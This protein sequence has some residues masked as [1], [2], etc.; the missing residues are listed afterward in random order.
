MKKFF[1]TAMFI[2][3]IAPTQGLIASVPPLDKQVLLPFINS[4]ASIVLAPQS[5]NPNPLPQRGLLLGEDQ[6]VILAAETLDSQLLNAMPGAQGRHSITPSSLH[7]TASIVQRIC[8]DYR[9]GAITHLTQTETKSLL[10]SVSVLLQLTH[11]RNFLTIDYELLENE[12]ILF[13]NR[14]LCVYNEGKAAVKVKKSD[15][16]RAYNLFKRSLESAR[17]VSPTII[18]GRISPHTV[19][20]TRPV[21]A[22][23]PVTAL[24]LRSV[25]TVPSPASSPATTPR[26][27]KHI[28]QRS[29]PEAAPLPCPNPLEGKAVAIASPTLGLGLSAADATVRATTSRGTVGPSGAATP[30][31]ASEPRRRKARS[32]RVVALAAPNPLPPKPQVTFAGGPK[33]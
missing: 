11:K 20:E 24:A 27:V 28:E 30:A 21:A 10:I 19:S 8:R 2:L 9:E 15:L 6:M 3:T 22:T 26:V 7:L 25:Q 23:R 5:P 32:E 16:L 29:L 1:I 4:Q 31:A 14:A 18:P 17:S 12:E 13:R 33:A